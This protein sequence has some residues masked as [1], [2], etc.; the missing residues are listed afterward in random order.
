M[1]PIPFR[2]VLVTAN[3]LSRDG[4]MIDPGALTWT[5]PMTLLVQLEDGHGGEPGPTQV[6][7]RIDDIEL[8]G[9]DYIGTGQLTTDVGIYQV[10]PMIADLTLNGVSVDTA[11]SVIEYRAPTPEQGGYVESVPVQQTLEE[12]AAPAAPEVDEAQPVER[13]SVNDVIMVFVEAEI[14]AAT[15]CAKPAM[16]GAYIEL[17]TPSDP[18][19]PDVPA[20]PTVAPESLPTTASARPIYRVFSLIAATPPPPTDT[21]P[22]AD[23]T[24]DQPDYSG[25]A[26]ICLM[27]PEA[28]TL[29][30]DGGTAAGELHITL[31]Y[32]GDAADIDPATITELQSICGELASSL[33][34]GSGSIAGPAAFVSDPD[35]E[36][37]EIPLVALI[38]SQWIAAVYA[39]LMDAL[40]ASA[41]DTPSEHGFIPHMT[42][43]YATA[44]SLLD[45]PPTDLSFPSICLVLGTDVQEFACGSSVTASAMG[46]APDEPP[47]SWFANPRLDHPQGLTVTDDGRVY[48]H[49]ASWNTCHTGM[50]GRCVK[51]P[52]S[53]SGYAYFLTGEL[54]TV[55]GD[56]V[57]VGQLTLDT[58]HASLSETRR[59]ATMHYEHTGYAVADVQVGED[60]HGIWVAG[61]VRPET[62][63]SKLRAFRACSI[64]GDWRSVG[65]ALE[66]IGALAVNIPGFPVPR[67][68]ARTVTASGDVT[69]LITG[70]IEDPTDYDRQIRALAFM[71]EHGEH[72]ID[73]LAASAAEPHSIDTIIATLETA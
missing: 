32:L 37:S 57:A 73:V 4:R 18:A 61:A 43:Q 68:Q 11:P 69:A 49:I 6:A 5:C 62:P 12:A 1:E 55:E 48:G 16:A 60:D 17:V 23:A 70:E 59:Q 65:G 26:M 45:I 64:S 34:E 20:S 52:R 35:P 53:R 31:A 39:A 22:D 66:L 27:P 56:R 67:P 42:L 28:S 8:V 41:I 44:P 10:A 19:A 51:P 15:I 38:D 54:R 24:G 25:G 40:S 30:V 21:A 71:A 46:A 50:A 7:G 14:I 9:D 3:K 2:A 36:A 33:E 13:H 58:T 72:T 63:A 29:A 47:V